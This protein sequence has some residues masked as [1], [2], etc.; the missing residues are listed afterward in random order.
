MVGPLLAT[1]LYL[2][3]P[4][5]A[6][7][8]R[9]RLRARLDH[10]AAGALTLVAAPAGCGKTTLLAEWLAAAPPDQRAAAWLAL[11]PGDNQPATFWAYLIAALRM[12]APGV[13]AGA[14]AA[15]QSPQPPPIEAV[16]A[17]LLNELAPLPRDLVLVLDDYHAIDARAIH[18]GMAFLLD[19]RPA[20]LHLVLAT[21]ADPP[22]PLARLRAR[23]E[24][25]EIRAADLRFTPDEAAAFLN[26]AMGLDLAADD[27]AA[28]AGSAD[29]GS[30]GA[31]CAHAGN[32]ERPRTERATR[33]RGELHR[34]DRVGRTLETLVAA[35][36]RA[37]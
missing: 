11:D 20:T 12:A 27:I 26:A 30:V 17:A 10:G 16:L 32:P 34:A 19:H 15:L 14:L 33:P 28:L 4:R 2:P 18:E 23:G 25:A 3:R 5:R 24:L 22:L 9:P 8:P 36:R 1:K 31:G 7:V 29:G 6:L 35:D 37:R 13:G 21:R